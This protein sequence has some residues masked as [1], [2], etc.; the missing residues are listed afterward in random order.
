M[1][2]EERVQLTARTDDLAAVR[3]PRGRHRLEDAPGGPPGPSPSPAP[4]P[5]AGLRRGVLPELL[6]TALAAAVYGW[7]VGAASPWRDEAATM[8]ICRRT[9]DQ[10]LDVTRTVDLVHLTFYLL[11]HVAVTIHDSVTSVRMI[12]VVALATAAGLVVRVG[13]RLGDRLTGTI[14]GGLLAA[15]PLASR[16]AQDARPFA[17]VTLAA[18]ISTLA[19]LRAVERPGRFLR[20]VLYGVTLAVLCPLNVIALLLIP[21]HGGYLLL[22]RRP[23]FWRWLLTAALASSACIPFLLA[24]FAQR[25]QVSWIP[26]PQLYD[27]T[28][29]YILSLASRAA[30]GAV[31]AAALV[32]A[33]GLLRHRGLPPGPGWAPLALGLAWAG[34][35]P[36]LLWGVSLVK[37]LWDLHYVLFSLPG[38]MLAVAALIR[39]VVRAIAG[40]APADGRPAAAVRRLRLTLAG[41]LAIASIAAAAVSGLPAQREQRRADGHGEDLKGVAVYLSEHAQAGDAVLFA[42]WKLRVVATIYP[43]LTRGLTDAALAQSPI[44]SATIHGRDVESKALRGRLAG[45]TRVWLVRGTYTNTPARSTTDSVKLALPSLGYRLVGQQTFTGYAVDL[46]RKASPKP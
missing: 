37:P 24:A 11:A 38:V 27:L 19:L 17:L 29:L 30:L 46:Y 40:R 2:I 42:P 7:G 44:S 32:L 39:L 6:A 33:V 15:S 1:P 12:S 25:E 36:V 21:A 43:D 35:P 45:H 14:A 13:R 31:A 16:W 5:S 4:P 10:I 20:W 18:V 9:L 8:A 23:P 41:A 22:T 3:P 28:A 26:R 34:V